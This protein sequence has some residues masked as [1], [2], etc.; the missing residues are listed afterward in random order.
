MRRL[1]LICAAFGLTACQPPADDTPGVF[2]P[3]NAARV[4]D[5]GCAFFADGT[6][7]QDQYMFATRQGDPDHIALAQFK[8]E[9]LKLVP[10]AVPSFDG[11]ALDITYDVLDYLNW[12]VRLQAEP[13]GQDAQSVGYDGS[14]TLSRDDSTITTRAD[15]YGE[16]RI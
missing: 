14:L 15:I 1:L 8:G 10:P 9:L 12:K 7:S 13:T 5:A 2:E 16:C 6:D 4:A 11:G 3:F